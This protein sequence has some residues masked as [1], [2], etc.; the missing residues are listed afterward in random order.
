MQKSNF[1]TSLPE[2]LQSEVLES[3]VT[4]SSV[5]I[6]R[7]ISKGH[8]SPD[9]GWHDQKEHEWVLVL[10]G[11]AI[12]EFEQVG[13]HELKAGDHVNIPCHAKHRV[14]WTDPDCVTIW[15]A[16]FY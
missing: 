15:L 9:S 2:N 13:K 10:Q 11:H 16:V 7:I 1:F 12:L 3:I 4:A 14:A 8:I 6:E 5:R